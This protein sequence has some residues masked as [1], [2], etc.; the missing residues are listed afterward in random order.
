MGKE[1]KKPSES[2]SL[3]MIIF[4]SSTSDSD[5]QLWLQIPV[6]DHIICVR[7]SRKLLLGKS[8]RELGFDSRFSRKCRSEYV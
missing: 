7:K 4:K 3:G 6:L 5:G 1:G 2:E 8:L